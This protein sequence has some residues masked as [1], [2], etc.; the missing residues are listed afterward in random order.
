[1][2]ALSPAGAGAGV[3]A[4]AGAAP[5]AGPPQA[6]LDFV[7]SLIN[8]L[9]FSANQA[10]TLIDDGYMSADDI[11]YWKNDDISKMDICKK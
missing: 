9:R 4:V 11:L 6:E 7:Q 8:V 1:M 3:G 2:A 5:A 10:A